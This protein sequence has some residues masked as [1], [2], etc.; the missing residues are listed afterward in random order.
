MEITIHALHVDRKLGNK[1]FTV[2]FVTW[3]M[4][5]LL[6]YVLLIFC[7]LLDV[8]L[9]G[10]FCRNLRTILF[11][12]FFIPLVKSFQ[13]FYFFIYF[14]LYIFNVILEFPLFPCGFGLEIQG[15]YKLF[16]FF[17]TPSFHL[18]IQQ[19]HFMISSI[20]KSQIC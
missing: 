2:I 20:E 10:R 1:H 3:P 7:F 17:H 19:R 16:T 11:E 14:V 15:C 9:Q 6:C 18:K 5:P 4:M 12:S 8:R 13:I